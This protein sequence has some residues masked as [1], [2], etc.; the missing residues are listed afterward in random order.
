ML[1][2]LEAT[3]AQPV[4]GGW[5]FSLK[6]RPHGKRAAV[7]IGPQERLCVDRPADPSSGVGLKLTLPMGVGSTITTTSSQLKSVYTE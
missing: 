3:T 7:K 5:G 1:V 6:S 4:P 2:S